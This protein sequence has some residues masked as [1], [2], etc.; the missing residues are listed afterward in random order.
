MLKDQSQHLYHLTLRLNATL[1]NT[2]DW[3][4]LVQMSH[5]EYQEIHQALTKK[6]VKKAGDLRRKWLGLHLDRIKLKL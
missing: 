2:G 6:D 4:D 3:N 5:D 1:F